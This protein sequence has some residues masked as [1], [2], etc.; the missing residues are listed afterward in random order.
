MKTIPFLLAGNHPKAYKLKERIAQIIKLLKDNGGKM[1][2][3]ELEQR[4]GLSR[5]QRPA[6]FY[7]P[8]HFMRKW[9]LLHVTKTVYLDDKGKKHFKTT[10]ELTPTMFYHYLEKN[11]VD[12]CRTEIEMV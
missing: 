10:Y 9:D 2:A 3:T 6:M 12:V 4:L 11:L 5:L 1:E 8:L 7:K